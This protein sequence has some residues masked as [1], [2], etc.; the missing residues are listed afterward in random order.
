MD[1]SALVADLQNAASALNQRP[2]SA[3]FPLAGGSESGNQGME[4]KGVL[5]LLD[6]IITHLFLFF[7]LVSS[8]LVGLGILSEGEE[9]LPPGYT[10][11]GGLSQKQIV[12]LLLTRGQR[13]GSLHGQSDLSQLHDGGGEQGGLALELRGSLGSLL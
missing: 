6:P 9:M 7:A 1:S 13:R 10:V 8:A 5:W 4:A 11:T 2:H 12:V 3:A